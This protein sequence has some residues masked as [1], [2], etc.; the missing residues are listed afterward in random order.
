MLVLFRRTVMFVSTIPSIAHT[1]RILA[2]MIY[3]PVKRTATSL[4]E[5]T[6]VHGLEHYVMDIMS[7]DN[8]LL[9]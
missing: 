3:S 1:H 7:K 4:N 2:R 8:P 6:Q 5:A 9:K